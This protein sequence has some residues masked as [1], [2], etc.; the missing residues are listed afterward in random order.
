MTHTMIQ[1]GSNS[2]RNAVPQ[3]CEKKG[4][5]NVRDVEGTVALL[6]GQSGRVWENRGIQ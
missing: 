4:N 3:L 1:N 5:S 2:K 6:T